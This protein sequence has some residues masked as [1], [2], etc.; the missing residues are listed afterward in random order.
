MYRLSVREIVYERNIEHKV[1]DERCRALV[2][3]FFSFLSSLI[4]Y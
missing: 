2:A 1:F 4:H 3:F